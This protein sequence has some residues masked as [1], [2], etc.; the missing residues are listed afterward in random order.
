MISEINIL[1]ITDST[2][3]EEN[4][5]NNLKMVDL[6][7]IDKLAINETYLNNRF[8]STHK[9]INKFFL[10]SGVISKNL[11]NILM[12]NAGSDRFRDENPG[13][14][15]SKSCFCDRDKFVTKEILKELGSPQKKIG[16]VIHITG[17][18]GKGSTASFIERIFMENGYK[19]NKFT[20]PAVLRNNENIMLNGVEIDD[21]EYYVLIKKVKDAYDKLMGDEKFLSE[22]ERIHE[23]DFNS[24]R[25]LY[26]ETYEKIPGWTFI[27][28]VLMLAFLNHRADVNVIEVINGGLKDFTNIFTEDEIMAVVITYMQYGIGRN[29]GTMRLQNEEGKW[30]S[31]NQATAYHKTMLSRKGRPLIITNQTPD[32]LREIKRVA[33]LN[34]A[35]TV[36]YNRD[37]FIRQKTEEGFVF[38]GLGRKIKIK[39]SKTLLEDYQ[40][41]NIATALAAVFS[42]DKLKIDEASI[43][44]AVDNT[45]V[46]G[47]LQYVNNGF[48]K[49][50]FEYCDNII[51]G[52]IKFN[53][54]AMESIERIISKLKGNIFIAYTTN[55]KK[56]RGE[57]TMFFNII[58][59]Y[60][61]IKIVIY[62]KTQEM[63]DFLI[64]EANNSGIKYET[65]PYL[66]LALLKIKSLLVP[67]EKN[68]VLI[69][70]NSMK[71]FDKN[72]VFLDRI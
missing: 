40:N 11:A 41:M 71:Q 26:R 36:E 53:N 69:L 15:R 16:P 30:Y 2:E 14:F 58:K 47:R 37:W 5:I 65:A 68:N 6:D 31:S 52:Y 44:K 45:W 50:Y 60:S 9:K 29:D 28:P 10:D 62:K 24:G 20:N 22:A 67:N 4:I 42:Q 32:V 25:I 13:I 38:E 8:F 21:E 34:E 7:K 56:T 12:K 70:C 33:K 43:Q 3:N 17:S 1:N 64:E 61:N 49:K 18:N 39:S 59:K 54:S 27:I 66:S 19:V 72:I 55:N 35:K 51:S 63:Y 23:N 46:A 57:N 48:Y